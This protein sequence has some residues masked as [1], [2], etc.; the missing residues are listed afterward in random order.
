MLKCCLCSERKDD[1]LRSVYDPYL[2]SSLRLPK[3]T[4][5]TLLSSIFHLAHHV[6]MS[7]SFSFTLPL[8]F[9]S[10]SFEDTL[11]LYCYYVLEEV[12]NIA[13]SK[14]K[15]PPQHLCWPITREKKHTSTIICDICLYWKQVKLHCSIKNSDSDV[16]FHSTMSILVFFKSFSFSHM[17]IVFPSQVSLKMGKIKHKRFY[18][19]LTLLIIIIID[20][21]Q[22]IEA[23]SI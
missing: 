14:D 6:C 2:Y 20:R 4:V 13:E 11:L 22:C 9:F 8:L 15:H 17:P 23:V 21:I 5:L 19:K 12:L 3:D 10:H 16:P 1:K 18:S 7:L